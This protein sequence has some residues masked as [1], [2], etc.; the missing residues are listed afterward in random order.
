MRLLNMTFK[1]GLLEGLSLDFSLDNRA[2]KFIVLAGENGTGK[3]TIINTIPPLSND[4]SNTVVQEAL[5][6]LNEKDIQ[7]LIQIDMDNDGNA[8]Y[9]GSKLSAS[10]FGNTPTLKLHKKQDQFPNTYIV[11]V[12][13]TKKFDY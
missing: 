5:F 4:Q 9:R 2:A 7:D 1:G 3:T 11:E 6:E 8:G 12:S 13:N 10:D